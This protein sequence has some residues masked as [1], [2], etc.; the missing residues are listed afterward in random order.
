ASL[1]ADPPSPVLGPRS[2][3]HRP[4]QDPMPTF[5]LIHSPLV[6]PFTWAPVADVLRERG[7]GAVVPALGA[8]EQTGAPYW[9][10]HADATAGVVKELAQDERLVLVGHSGAGALLPAVRGSLGRPVDA[11]LF[12]DA[13]LP[14]DGA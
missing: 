8:G 3:V 1:G 4:S 12:V 13:G 5:V 11:Y 14:R 2:S 9:R 10:Q 7:V 6:G